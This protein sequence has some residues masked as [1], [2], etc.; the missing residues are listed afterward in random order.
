MLWEVQWRALSQ[1]TSNQSTQQLPPPS[2]L[3]LSPFLPTLAPVPPLE[4][5]KGMEKEEGREWRRR[6]DSG[7]CPNH[8]L[9]S[10]V[11]PRV[12]ASLIQVAVIMGG[13]RGLSRAVF[14]FILTLVQVL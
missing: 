3:P 8:F 11:E 9:E 13:P 14:E 5:K 10:W 7:M 1:V 6:V 2:L 12:S 4:I